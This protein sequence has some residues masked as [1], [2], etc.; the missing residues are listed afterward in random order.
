MLGKERKKDSKQTNKQERKNIYV[1]VSSAAC[2]G[3]RGSHF[4]SLFDV[5]VQIRD[6]VDSKWY[7][8]PPPP[9]PP[10]PSPTA[11]LSLQVSLS[12]CA[13]FALLHADIS[14]FTSRSLF[15]P[16]YAYRYLC[17]VSSLIMESQHCSRVPLINWHDGSV[18]HVMLTKAVQV[19]WGTEGEVNLHNIC[20]SIFFIISVII[21]Q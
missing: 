12:L 18:V 10:P 3:K 6:G 9:P 4:I 2:R 11:C 1:H 20:I 19:N 21:T 16:S 8:N 13:P 17:W 5:Q 7:V 15:V 14:V